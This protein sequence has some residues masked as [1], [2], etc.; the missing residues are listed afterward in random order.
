MRGGTHVCGRYAGRGVTYDIGWYDVDMRGIT[1]GRGWRGGYRGRRAQGNNVDLGRGSRGNADVPEMGAHLFPGTSEDVVPPA[2]TDSQVLTVEEGHAARVAQFLET[3]EVVGEAGDDVP[4]AC[5]AGGQGGECQLC[6]G[7]GGF[8]LAS[9]RM[10][11]GVWR[12][13]IEV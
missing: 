10:D 3:D 4:G 8:C 6:G 5:G 9:G 1:H 2:I 7:H 12:R 13:P 11:G